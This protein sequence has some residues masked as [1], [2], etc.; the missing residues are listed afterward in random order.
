MAITRWSDFFDGVDEQI[1]LILTNLAS[2]REQ[3]AFEKTNTALVKFPGLIKIINELV[4]TVLNERFKLVAK[5]VGIISD[6][7]MAAKARGVMVPV[8]PGPVKKAAK[9]ANAAKFGQATGTLLSTMRAGFSADSILTTMGEKT[10]HPGLSSFYILSA[11]AEV[12]IQYQYELNPSYFYGPVN[13][14]A[15]PGLLDELAQSE[16]H[17]SLFDINPYEGEA[18]M[19]MAMEA[20]KKIVSVAGMIEGTL[21]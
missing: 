15:Y 1:E 14:G 5:K 7:W 19:S 9:A 12:P 3:I 6:S 8:Y 4:M 20:Y 17:Y 13:Q 11:G 21:G 18:I 2:L 16:I 10:E